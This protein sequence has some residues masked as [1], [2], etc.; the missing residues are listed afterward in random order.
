MSSKVPDRKSDPINIVGAGVFGL[1]TAFHLA[2]RGYT[3]VTVFD[4]QPYDETEYSYFNG[5]D[6]ASA[7]KKSVSGRCFGCPLISVM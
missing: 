6:A 1:S 4:K 2:N 3:K 5:C 7:G